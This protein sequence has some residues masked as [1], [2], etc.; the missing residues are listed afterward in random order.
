MYSNNILN[1]QDSITNLNAYTK[2]RRCG[3]LLKAP[4]MLFYLF[5]CTVLCVY[6]VLCIFIAQGG[7]CD[8]ITSWVLL[9]CSLCCLNIPVVDCFGCTY[10]KFP[11]LM[12]NSEY[13][14]NLCCF[15]IAC[16]LV[17]KKV[18][19]FVWFFFNSAFWENR[20]HDNKKCRYW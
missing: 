7:L 9:F 3:N 4:R 20:R 17:C 5:L 8:H 15:Y 18:S 6:I 12:P 19:C 16:C 14:Y 13:L 1:F 2:K 11:L 10:H